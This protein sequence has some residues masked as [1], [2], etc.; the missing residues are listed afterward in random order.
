MYFVK[1]ITDRSNGRSEHSNLN[2]AEIRETARNQVVGGRQPP[3]PLARL[4]APASAA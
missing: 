3:T 1:V 4:F 2:R